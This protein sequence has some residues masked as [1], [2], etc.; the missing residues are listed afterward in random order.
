MSKID[1]LLKNEKVEWKKLGEVCQISKGKQFNKRDMLDDGTYPVINGGIL[2]SGYIDLFNRNENT[3]T[4]SQGGA[5]A[6]YVNFI[7]EK[8]W[9]GA[10]A[11]SVV[12]DN[13]IINEYDYEY[14]CFNRF[15]FHILKMNQINLQD[16]KEG[17]GIPS[18]SK[19]RLSIIEVPLTTKQV[20]Q[21]IVKTLD[22]FTNYVTELQAELQARTK[23][24]EYYRDMLL[25]EEYLNKLSNNPEILGGGYSLK[26][27]TLEEIV[28]IKNG[29]DW[30]TL[31][32]GNIPV[33]GSG[34]KMNIFVDKYSYNKPSV[35]IPRKGSIE[36]VFYVEEPF[37]N[38]DTIFYTEID[39]EK[40]IPKY[41]YYFIENY[42]MAKLSTDSTRPSLTQSILNKVK[43][44]LPP[45][46]IQNKV[47][48]I[49]DKFQSL[50][51]DTKG[52]LPQEIEQRQKQYEYYREKLLTFDENSV[53]RERERAYLS[54]SYLNSLKEA[55]EIV[56]VSVFG[57]KLKRLEDIAEL[58]DG[59]HQTPKYVNTGVPFVSVQDI[60]NIYGTNKYI[61]A[62]EYNK[63]KVKPRKNDVFMTRIGD[64]GTCAIVENDDDLAYYV[65]LTLIRPSNDIVLSKFLKY[66]IESSQ[67]K[68]ELSKRILHNATPIKINLGEIGKLQF[69]IPSIP[70]QEHIVS[71][72]DK[73]DSIVN[74]ISKG[75][76]KE[77]ELRQKQ[78]EH[79]REKLLSFNR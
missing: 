31:G 34:G 26:V 76:P 57:V 32:K 24:Y 56:E 74:D 17:A 43:I 79:Y 46:E 12:P 10:H 44:D 53:K 18:V 49:L 66:L 48:E 64:I 37:W 11:F 54:N 8:F 51:A 40:I 52:L 67:G 15:L 25:S 59:T 1:E 4:V 71:I 21:K 65:T 6:G 47:V 14:S 72:L 30:K 22:K 29:K 50:L 19:D 36:N 35:L 70:V 63:F 9:L 77:I 16:S 73:F 41:L 55:G 13:D 61:T 20:Q 78:Y 33:Y 75:L 68:K 7:E 62:E 5:S 69:L 2:P 39:D 27:T 23:Q 60:K 58:Y 45:I 42:D 38:V 28:K 3:I